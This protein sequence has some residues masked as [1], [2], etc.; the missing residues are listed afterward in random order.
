MAS[1]K[2][3]L[4]ILTVVLAAVLIYA[5][6]PSKGEE[7]NKIKKVNLDALK[8]TEDETADSLTLTDSAQVEV[9][10]VDTTKQRILLVGESM[11]EGLSRPFADYCAANGHEYN[12]VCWYSSTT[13]HWAVTD[14]LQH[15]INKFNPTYVF[16]TIGGNELFVK[17]LDNRERYIKRIIEVVGDRNLAWIGT[18]AWKQDTGICDLTQ[19]LVGKNRY[20]DSR[21]LKLERG[22]DHAHPT[23]AAAVVWM[24]E[25]VKW[26]TSFDCKHPIVLDKYTQKAKDKHLILL[27][28]S[29]I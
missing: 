17:D 20:F 1:Q 25:F 16:I 21:G 27:S 6:I 23:F 22:K 13:K 7:E 18:P 8:E 24:D 5:C 10:Q 14:T 11:V 12:A 26:V 15:F 9:Q 29:A 3:I 28:P 4:M 19:K 2:K